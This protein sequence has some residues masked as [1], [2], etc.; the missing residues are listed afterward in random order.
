M[1]VAR[2]AD[3]LFIFSAYGAPAPVDGGADAGALAGDAMFVQMFDFASG[4]KRGPSKFLFSIPYG[5]VAA[6]EDVSV[7]PTGEIALLYY[8]VA[9]PTITPTRST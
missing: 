3:T 7:A 2:N 6:V 4:D 1:A 5:V 8:V 9:G